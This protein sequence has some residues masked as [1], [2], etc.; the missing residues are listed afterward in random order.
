MSVTANVE[1]ICAIATPPGVGGIGIVRVS[2]PEAAAIAAGVLGRCPAP[3]RARVGAFLDR[4]G[5]AIDH[6]VALFFAGPRSYTGEDVLELQGHGGIA[7][8]DLV[9]KRVIE[10][11]ARLARPGEFTERAFLN[12][13]IDL[14]QAEAVADLIAA[15]SSEAARS[16][17]RSLDGVFSDQVNDLQEQ[18]SR[19][20]MY[21]ESA[22][23]FPEE[24]IDFLNDGEVARMLRALEEAVSALLHGAKQGA[25]LQD[26]AVVVLTGKP[27]AG[28]ST[29]LNALSGAERA[30]VTEIAGTTRDVLREAITLDGVRIT[31]VDTA[32]IQESDNPIEREGIRRALAEIEHADLVLQV[33]DATDKEPSPIDAAGAPVLRVRNKLD[34][35]DARA[36]EADA[37]APDR[38]ADADLTEVPISARTGEGLDRLRAAI[39]K[40]IGHDGPSEGAFSARRR[41]VL[42]LET[43]QSVVLRGREALAATGAG[44]LLAADLQAAQDALSELT[45][46]ITPD[47]LLGRIF[48]EFCIGK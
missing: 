25:L 20:R 43:V 18:L 29:L 47:D 38:R 37:G 45:G 14:A 40:A 13:R 21:V 28:K 48:S 46:T 5:T 6:G 4:D 44:E 11:G 7:V 1:T 23:D 17:L 9:L 41:H 39:L 30:I 12:E 35:T 19:T 2:G 24:E 32:G 15:T 42:A 10:L 31:L 34:L 36:P 16:A 8:L 33:I 3:R 26:G 22:L 27:N